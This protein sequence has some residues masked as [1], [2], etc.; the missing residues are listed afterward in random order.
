LGA[1]PRILDRVY[2]PSSDGSLRDAARLNFR[3]RAFTTAEAPPQIHPG[4]TVKGWAFFLFPAGYEG[5]NGSECRFRLT[6]EDALG[7][8][9][10]AEIS[11]Q[12]VDPRSFFFGS[13][14]DSFYVAGDKGDISGLP[15]AVPEY[16]LPT[17]RA[18]Q[19]RLGSAAVRLQ[20][21][22]K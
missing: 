18:L 1:P 17:F 21:V 20:P 13:G 10:T 7:A 15:L 3:G 16:L 4:Q 11:R 14:S 5:K 2:V 6:V 8:K 22:R 19:S 12:V 9:E